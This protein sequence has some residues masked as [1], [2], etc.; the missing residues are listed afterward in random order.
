MKKLGRREFI[1]LTTVA[2]AGC[3]VGAAPNVQA[4][5]PIKLT[6][7]DPQAKQLGYVSDSSA[8]ADTARPQKQPNQSCA[9]CSLLQGNVGDEWRPCAIFPGKVVAAKGWCTVW[10]PKA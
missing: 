5:E 7:D 4:D 2:A 6:A 10:A 8:V 3:F 9:T 1:Q